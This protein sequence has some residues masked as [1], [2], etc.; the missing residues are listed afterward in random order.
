MKTKIQNKSKIEKE[1]ISKLLHD[2]NF[3]IGLC[4][5]VVM[6]FIVGAG[7]TKY[8]N[9]LK[10]N[11]TAAITPLAAHNSKIEAK[12]AVITP[13]ATAAAMLK[14]QQDTSVKTKVAVKEL[15]NT[16]GDTT[17]TVGAHD[18]FWKISKAACGTGVYYL[19]IKQFNGYQNRTLHPGD[20]LT[21]VC[22]E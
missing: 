1:D 16:T 2:K 3:V 10:A 12:N 11:K 20:V 22:A 17:Y 8:A 18:N 9:Y 6:F 19:S 4:V 13:V 21:I 5:F 15:P 14:S 7:I